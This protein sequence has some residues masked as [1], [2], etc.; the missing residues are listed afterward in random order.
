MK[1]TDDRR[2]ARAFGAISLLLVA[3]SCSGT[4]EFNLPTSEPATWPQC[5]TKVPPVEIRY[6]LK[7]ELQRYDC[8]ELVDQIAT[9][10][11]TPIEAT[12]WDAPTFFEEPLAPTRVEIWLRVH[13]FPEPSP[14]VL[15]PARFSEFVIGRLE[16][17]SHGTRVTRNARRELQKIVP[18]TTSE[19]ELE[20]RGRVWVRVTG[21][22]VDDPRAVY[23]ESYLMP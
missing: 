1:S 21:Y 13:E 11:G 19:D 4:G 23:S 10:T 7:R 20:V 5:R 15:S 14:E 8:P 12:L 17:G 3:A 22:E 2:L 18:V 16:V 6:Q 9:H